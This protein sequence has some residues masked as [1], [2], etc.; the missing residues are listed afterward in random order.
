MTLGINSCINERDGDGKL[1][2]EVIAP[3]KLFF[4]GYL[5][6]QVSLYSNLISEVCTRFPWV[7]ILDASLSDKLVY[8][9]FNLK[10]IAV[11]NDF[12]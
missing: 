2:L 8:L 12:I 10:M 1:L 4:F 6:E 3:F 7:S 5:T 11:S 9:E